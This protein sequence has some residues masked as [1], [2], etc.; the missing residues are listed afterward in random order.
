MRFLCDGQPGGRQG[1]SSSWA[2]PPL[3]LHILCGLPSRTSEPRQWPA[4]RSTGSPLNPVRPPSCKMFLRQQMPRQTRAPRFAHGR[5]HASP[6]RRVRHT[7]TRTT[8]CGAACASPASCFDRLPP[9][10]PSPGNRPTWS[11]ATTSRRLPSNSAC[12]QALVFRRLGAPRCQAWPR[13]SGREG[14]REEDAG[15]RRVSAGERE[16]REGCVAAWWLPRAPRCR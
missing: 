7:C 10:R 16:G 4:K 8:H 2:P 6:A 9:P 5:G 13:E 3:S 15:A 1:P 11:V 12:R 14:E